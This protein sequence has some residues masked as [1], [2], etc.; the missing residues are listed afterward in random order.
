MSQYYTIGEL[1][2]TNKVNDSLLFKPVSDEEFYQLKYGRKLTTSSFSNDI[3]VK[4]TNK[5]SLSPPQSNIKLKIRL[6]FT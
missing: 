5:E 4:D 6:H 3:E 1:S 2:H